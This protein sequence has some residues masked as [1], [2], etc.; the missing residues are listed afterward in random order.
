M[1]EW[2]IVAGALV[3]GGLMF[4]WSAKHPPKPIS[5]ADNQ[6]PEV[7]PVW[8]RL[9]GGVIGLFTG[10]LIAFVADISGLRGTETLYRMCILPAVMLGGY[11]P[12][13]FLAPLSRL[14]ASIKGKA[15]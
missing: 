9:V 13:L 11:H 14:W 7:V 15:R 5:E 8:H 4:W 12:H 2:L 6:H 10:L 3:F 1:S